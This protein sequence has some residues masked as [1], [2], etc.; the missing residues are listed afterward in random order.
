MRTVLF[1]T[2]LAA[3]ALS[4]APAAAATIFSENFDSVGVANYGTGQRVGG[5]TVT[6]NDVDVFG[7]PEYAYACPSPNGGDGN[8]CVDMQGNGSGRLQT[9]ALT[10]VAGQTYTIS[11]GMAGNG[12]N[13]S[14]A[15]YV[16][17][18]SFGGSTQTFSVLPVTPFQTMSFAVTAAES[19]TTRL[20]FT[21]LP[22][23]QPNYWGAI[24]DDVSVTT[25]DPVGA[26]VPEPATWATMIGGFGLIGRAMRRRARG[27][28]FA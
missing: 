7:H 22:G 24:L 27:R 12:D 26:A 25:P 16:L 3:A 5:F 8:H 10:I 20:Q 1:T 11:F 4:A 21:A 9:D 28:A 15:P 18:A 17:E 23:Y 14:G 2:A 19:G 6:Q 13:G